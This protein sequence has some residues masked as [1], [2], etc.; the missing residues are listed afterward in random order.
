MLSQILF[1]NKTRLDVRI[2]DFCTK[3]V[4]TIVRFVRTKQ[5]SKYNITSNHPPLLIELIQI[6]VFIKQWLRM[7]LYDSQDIGT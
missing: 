1:S 2:V 7:A 6:N 5:L 3:S 4:L